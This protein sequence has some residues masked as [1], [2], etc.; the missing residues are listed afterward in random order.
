MF[1]RSRSLHQHGN[2][3]SRIK[4]KKKVVLGRQNNMFTVAQEYAMCCTP[5]QF[6]FRA[7]DTVHGGE[8]QYSEVPSKVAQQ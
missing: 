5:I 3:I 1:G 8:R 4:A 2:V 6:N 7:G